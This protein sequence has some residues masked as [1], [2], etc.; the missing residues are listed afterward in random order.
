MNRRALLVLSFLAATAPAG[1]QS[2][3]G[4]RGLGVAVD[5]LDPRARALSSLGTGLLGLNASLVNPADLAGIRRRGV[6]ATLQPFFGSAEVAGRTDDVE[7]TR[8]PLI[9]IMYPVRQRVVVGVG[10]G[11]FLEQSW[12]VSSSSSEVIGGS[13]V[14]TDEVISARGAISQ[15]RLSASFAVKP[16]FALGA[17]VGVYTGDLER[18]ITRTFPDTTIGLI[19]FSRLNV[20]EYRGY[21]AA[22]GVRV[23]PSNRTR[24]A[25]SLTFSSDL[26]AEPDSSIARSHSYAMPLRFVV[27]GSALVAPRLLATA[28]AQYANWSDGSDYAPPGTP[29]GTT[30]TGRPAWE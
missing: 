18:Q 4:M 5:P 7:S 30:M 9:Q 20:W 16:S 8:F 17:A 12:A 26:D 11:G 28:S 25:A 24:I 14:L 1:A 6:V 23:D 27:G 10:Y 15:A 21:L 19:G 3:F 29:V 22:L 2:L 13:N